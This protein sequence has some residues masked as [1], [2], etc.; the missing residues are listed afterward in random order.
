LSTKGADLTST[1]RLLVTVIKMCFEQKEWELLNEHILILT[2]RR[3]QLKQAVTK[4]I[5]EAFTYVDQTP[6]RETKLKFI[7][8]LRTVTAGKVEGFFQLFCWFYFCTEDYLYSLGSSFR[9]C[10]PLPDYNLYI[11]PCLRIIDQTASISKRLLTIVSSQS[12]SQIF[13][14]NFFMLLSF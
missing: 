1:T 12:F 10:S 11:V 9:G 3:N 5:Q 14:V 6:D 7:E 8:T 2:K 4:M 13:V